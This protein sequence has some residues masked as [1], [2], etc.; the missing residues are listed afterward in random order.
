MAKP[1]DLRIVSQI[2]K[3]QGHLPPSPVLLLLPDGQHQSR[4]NEYLLSPLV[5]A[6]LWL[7]VGY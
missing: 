4:D 7:C 5:S 6:T 2:I 1:C 3:N